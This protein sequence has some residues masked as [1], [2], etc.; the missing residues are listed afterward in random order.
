M[1]D[2]SRNGIYTIRVS[3]GGG[4]TR[5]TADPGGD[6]IPGDFSPEGDQ[7]VFFGST[8]GGKVGSSSPNST[9]TTSTGSRRRG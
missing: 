5:I 2:P 1:D 8:E 3:D 6:D 4:L 7:L 9:G